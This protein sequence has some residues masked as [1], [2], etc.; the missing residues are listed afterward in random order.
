VTG[1]YW[2]LLYIIHEGHVV[3]SIHP[4]PTWTRVGQQRLAFINMDTCKTGEDSLHK[5]GY[6]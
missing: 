2:L 6:L 5:H 1:I 4:T 3:Y